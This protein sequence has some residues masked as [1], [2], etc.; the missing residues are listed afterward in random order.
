M[1]SS[2]SSLIRASKI[3]PLVCGDWA[4]PFDPGP[5]RHHPVPRGLPHPAAPVRYDTGVSSVYGALADRLH[6]LSFHELLGT[7]DSIERYGQQLSPGRRLARTHS[8][9]AVGANCAD[10]L[11]VSPRQTYEVFELSEG[12]VLI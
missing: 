4:F 11:C 1:S 9:A 7:V 8:A 12:S 6:F 10:G 2:R 5:R 3:I